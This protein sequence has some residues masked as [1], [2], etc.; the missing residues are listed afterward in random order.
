MKKRIVAILILL[1]LVLSGCQGFK[2]GQTKEQASA[3]DVHRGVKGVTMNF[4][5]NA[6]PDEL[7]EG[8]PLDILIELRNEG[9]AEATGTLYLSGYDATI[10][11]IQ[12]QYTD[13][14]LEARSTFNTLGG[15][16]PKTFSARNVAL[17]SG[18]DV[19]NQNFLAYAC[20]NYRT[21]ADI[22]VCI[23]PNPL[24]VLENEVCKPTAPAVGGGQGGPVSITAIKEDAA[25]G[26]VG[27]QIT[28]TN[29]G[30]GQVIEKNSMNNCPQNLKFNDVDTVYYAVRLQGAQ[31]DCEPKQRARIA[32]GKQGLIYCRFTLSDSNSLAYQSVLEVDL[33]YG[34]LSKVSKTI[35]VK[36]VP[37]G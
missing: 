15:Y 17:P 1:V 22:Q 24:S 14:T 21:E 31:G 18:V 32:T 11:P 9:A 34:Y 33:D 20:Y 29:Q 13:F 36:S 19:L 28:I 37:N 2:F 6:P 8:S 27:F 10:F 4:V 3:A 30:D 35:R 5:R 16:E 25:P 23:D 7:F 12:P 26:K